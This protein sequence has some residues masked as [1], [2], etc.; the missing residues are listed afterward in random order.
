M[1]IFV[2]GALRCDSLQL[3]GWVGLLP[4]ACA[5]SQRPARVSTRSLLER[6]RSSPRVVPPRRGGIGRMTKRKGPSAPSVAASSAGGR[7]QA[8]RAPSSRAS[9]ASVTADADEDTVTSSI[10][11][12]RNSRGHTSCTICQASSKAV[13][14]GATRKHDGDT[15]PL[16]NLCAG[17]VEFFK[18]RK[19]ADLPDLDC[20][21]RRAQGS[22]SFRAEIDAAKKV[23]TGGAK[24]FAE[25]RTEGFRFVGYDLVTSYMVLSEREVL[26]HF[27]RH[28]WTRLPKY[29]TKDLIQIEV[30][31][32]R[33]P[34]KMEKCFLF[35][36]PDRPFREVLLR[37]SMGFQR[38]VATMSPAQQIYAG[39]GDVVLGEHSN[40]VYNTEAAAMASERALA[41]TL[42]TLDEFLAKQLKKDD[43]S[44]AAPSSAACD[45]EDAEG[46]GESGDSGTDEVAEGLDGPLAGLF[47]KTTSSAGDDERRL[48]PVPPFLTPP[49][50]RQRLAPS[51]P[52]S[53][54][55]SSAGDD[56][57][58]D[59][60]ANIQR[61]DGRLGFGAGDLRNCRLALRPFVFP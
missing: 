26:R 32:P 38:S 44:A 55:A 3:R 14:W 49:A 9:R 1:C 46:A 39:Q 34:L 52:P 47:G 30:P 41:G 18:A 21:V 48:P 40:G 29:V 42:P 60:T 19:S 59:E 2:L 50:K 20:F 28:Q 23:R 17:C 24:D 6:I 51:P 45:L 25:E 15:V 61:R 8:K 43:K 13:A 53:S 56:D 7:S 12:D 35:R 22:S 54:R 58:E 33:E 4:S 37:H 10:G 36:N 27:R 11:Y 16:G 31:A 57:D 5:P